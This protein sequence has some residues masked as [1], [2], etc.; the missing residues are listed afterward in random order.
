MGVG[1][2]PLQTQ[3]LSTCGQVSFRK[4]LKVTDVVALSGVAHAAHIP[5]TPLTRATPR[6]RALDR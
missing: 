2:I 3:T 4:H 5:A 6:R 1:V